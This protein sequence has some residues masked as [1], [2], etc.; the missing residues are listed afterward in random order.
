M[1]LSRLGLQTEYTAFSSRPPPGCWF[2]LKSP[3]L[4]PYS[5]PLRTSFRLPLADKLH[6]S[7]FGELP[8]RLIVIQPCID[9]TDVV[10]FSTGAFIQVY[11]YSK[12][13]LHTI[14]RHTVSKITNIVKE[15]L[16]GRQDRPMAP[17]SGEAG[18]FLLES[19][20]MLRVIYNPVAGP[21]IVSKIDRVQSLLSARGIPFEIVKTSGPGDAVLLAGEAA[22]AGAEAVV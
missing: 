8:V 21:K 20:H 4:V 13:I 11:S 5:L 12:C 17:F 9:V 16:V 18:R 7:A 19:H 1:A 15:I 3:T 14:Y 6:D 22:G 10:N 2:P